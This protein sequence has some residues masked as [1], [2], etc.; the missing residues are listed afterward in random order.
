MNR[1]AI[2][3]IGDMIRVRYKSKWLI[4]GRIE[5]TPEEIID[6]EEYK[7]FKEK[8]PELCRLAEEG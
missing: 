3:E 4:F 7:W 2:F 6:S 8:R 1:K 5:L